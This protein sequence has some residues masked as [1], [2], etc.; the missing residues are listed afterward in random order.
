MAISDVD[1]ANLALQYC[2]TAPIASFDEPKE[3]ARAL[4]ASYYTLRDTLLRTYCWNFARKYA[5]LP[6][7][8]TV[9]PF[10]YEY[11]YQ[12][13]DDFMRLEYASQAIPG[14][15]SSVPGVTSPANAITLPGVDLSDYQAGHS[16]DYRIVGRQIYAHLPPPLCV[17]YWMRI[18]DPN[19]FDAAFIETFACYLAWKL[20]PR[21]NGSLS[22]KRD[23]KEDFRLSLFGA[24]TSNAV[25]L[26]PVQIPDDT[27]L[28]SRQSC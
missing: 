9:P 8:A 11:A 23:L 18:T 20:G 4:K 2:E 1:I 24:R 25:E 6:Q 27:F 22:K 16:Q 3:S 15:G 28:L 5:Q 10:E 7:L 17:S 14:S 13:P 12:L 21:I 19:Q 26:P